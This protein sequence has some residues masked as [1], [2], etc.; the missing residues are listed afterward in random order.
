MNNTESNTNKPIVE[1][2]AGGMAAFLYLV[3]IVML[4]IAWGYFQAAETSIHEIECFLIAMMGFITFC[5]GAVVS[6]LNRI[7][8]ALKAACE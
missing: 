3:G 2:T 5:G 8:E 1:Q 4:V 6:Q 7:R